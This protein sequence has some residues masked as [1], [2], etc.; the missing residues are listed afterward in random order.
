MS[1]NSKQNQSPMTLAHG[2]LI[3]EETKGISGKIDHLLPLLTL[4]GQEEN[5][6]DGDP[7]EQI[8][9]LLQQIVKNQS[10]HD[11]ALEDLHARLNSIAELFDAHE[12]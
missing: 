11:Q 6:S 4:L 5:S 10:R 1:D 12:P 8:V 3:H 9:M 7:V 2:R